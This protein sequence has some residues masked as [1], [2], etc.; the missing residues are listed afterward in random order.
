MIN[1]LPLQEKT[2][3]RNEYLARISVVSLF[4]FFIVILIGGALLAPIIVSSSNKKAEL[5]EKRG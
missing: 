2:R 1:L 4:F 3:I 5:E